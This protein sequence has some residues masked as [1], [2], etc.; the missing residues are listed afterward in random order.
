MQTPSLRAATTVAVLALVALVATG[1]GGSS[2][3]KTTGS[4]A[5]NAV[6]Q[7]FV[8]QMIP[9]HEMAVQMANTA[10]TRGQH[11]RSPP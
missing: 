3:T 7:A 5:Q 11:P 10:A 4:T 9:H 6:D 8:Q 1:C 2:T